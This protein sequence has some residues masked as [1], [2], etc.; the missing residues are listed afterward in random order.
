MVKTKKVKSAGRFGSR[1]GKKIRDNISE[2]ESKSRAKYE[3]P[4]C[5]SQ[6]LKRISKGVWYCKKCKKKV[7]GGAYS[8]ETAATKLIKQSI[9]KK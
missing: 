2:V 8:P 4:S 5:L 9:T 3:C 6:S 1:Y 7:A